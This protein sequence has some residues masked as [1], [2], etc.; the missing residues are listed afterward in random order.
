MEIRLSAKDR[1]VVCV[2]TWLLVHCH[3]ERWSPSLLLLPL[4]VGQQVVKIL[5][6]LLTLA[7]R[8]VRGRAVTKE[9]SRN[10]LMSLPPISFKRNFCY[11]KAGIG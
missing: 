9:P 6:V 8:A 4:Q 7:A 1:D 5:G 2:C 3:R 10:V 11:L